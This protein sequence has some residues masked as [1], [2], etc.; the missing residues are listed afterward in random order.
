MPSTSEAAFLYTTGIVLL[1]L[2]LWLMCS[3][4]YRRQQWKPKGTPV[5]WYI[6]ELVERR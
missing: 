2:V 4:L 6:R 5:P 3:V 1:C